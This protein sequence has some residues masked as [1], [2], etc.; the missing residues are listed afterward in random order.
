MLMFQALLALV[1]ER[2]GKLRVNKGEEAREP[3]EQEL[4]MSQI[5]W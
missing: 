2:E 5:I 1:I 3:P 4:T